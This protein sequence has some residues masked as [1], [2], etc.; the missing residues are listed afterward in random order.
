MTTVLTTPTPREEIRR[1][2]ERS[3]GDFFKAVVDLHRGRMT[4]GGALHADQEALLREQGSRQQDLWGINLFP[5]LPGDDMVEF[6]A[7]ST[8]G[9]HR[10]IARAPSR[11]RRSMR[12]SP[13]SFTG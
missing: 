6:D 13:I 7:S 3:F 9:R 11:I 1:H 12:R 4:V 8:S 2:A 5:A 10:G